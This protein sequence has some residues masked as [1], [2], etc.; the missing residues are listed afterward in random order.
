LRGRPARSASDSSPANVS[1]VVDSTR[2][3]PMATVSPTAKRRALPR[4]APPS[5]MAGRVLPGPPQVVGKGRKQ[6]RLDRREVESA[7]AA[8]GHAF[9]DAAPA[10]PA[11]PSGARVVVVVLESILAVAPVQVDRGDAI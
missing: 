9:V 5:P 1:R 2:K 8:Q 7:V 4:P 6:A 10:V 3:P 11:R